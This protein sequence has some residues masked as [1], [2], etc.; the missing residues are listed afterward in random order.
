MR[1]LNRKR[2]W[3]NGGQGEGER[4]CYEDTRRESGQGF[5]PEN[6]DDT[7]VGGVAWDCQLRQAKA[8]RGLRTAAKVRGH[9]GRDGSSRSLQR[10]SLQEDMG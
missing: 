3:G 1:I 7:S 9:R 6:N 4:E 10:I 8:V 2:S 5:S